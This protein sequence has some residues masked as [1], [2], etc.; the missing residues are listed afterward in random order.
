MDEL[1]NSPPTME[2]LL[3]EMSKITMLLTKLTEENALLRQEAENA[4][5]ENAALKCN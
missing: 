1:S 5:R 2:K 4:R 3:A